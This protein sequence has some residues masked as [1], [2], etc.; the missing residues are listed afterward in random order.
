MSGTGFTSRIED[1]AAGNSTTSTCAPTRM[2][3]LRSIRMYPLHEALAR[4]RIRDEHQSSRRSRAES[5]L[6]AHRH[7][8]RVESRARARS[9]SQ[10]PAG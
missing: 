5:E 1:R 6:S 9:A 8:H 2:S 4:E 3:E 7:W 10:R